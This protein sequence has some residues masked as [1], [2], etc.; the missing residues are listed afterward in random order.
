MAALIARQSVLR[1]SL[2][3]KPAK[4][5]RSTSSCPRSAPSLTLL[6]LNAILKDL[7]AV[8]AIKMAPVLRS[9]AIL[10][11]RVTSDNVVSFNEGEECPEIEGPVYVCPK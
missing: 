11:S 2:S 6:L 5:R 3:A 9:R 8:L 7:L 4:G 10:A 1:A